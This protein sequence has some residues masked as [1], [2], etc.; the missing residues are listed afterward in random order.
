MSLISA[1]LALLLAQI[2]SWLIAKYILDMRYYPFI[3]ASCG[4]LA[5]TV[6]LVTGVGVLASRSILQHR[7]ALFLR[8]HTE[9]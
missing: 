1:L 7:P 3:G 6:S 2:G 9:D 5:V 8:E 4:L